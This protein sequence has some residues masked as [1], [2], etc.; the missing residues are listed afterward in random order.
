MFKRLYIPSLFFGLFL[1]SACSEWDDHYENS[2]PSG[3]AGAPLWDQLKS[4]ANLSDFCEVLENT[5]LYRMHKKTP[6]TYADLLKNGQAFTVLAP[7]NN[8]FNKDSLLNLVQTVSGDSAVEKSFVQNHLS[9]LLV[10]VNADSVRMMMLN[11]KRLNVVNGKVEGVQVAQANKHSRNGVLHVL[12]KAVDY[13]RNIY[14]MLCDHPQLSEIGMNLSRFNEDI[15]DPDASVSNGVIE[16]VPVYIDSV[17]YER[18]RMLEQIGLLKEEDSVYWAVVPTTQGWKDAWEVV[19]TYYVF[20]KTN[21]KR[22]SL[23]HYFTM[24][25]LLDDAIFNKT[26]QWDVNDSLLSV[27]YIRNTHSYAKGKHVYNVFKEP[28]KEGGILYGSEPIECSNGIVYKTAKW[29]FTPE[30]T[31]FHEVFV[32]GEAEY[33]MTDYTKCIYHFETHVA[34]SVSENKYIVISPLSSTD[35]WSVTYQLN[36]ILSGCYDIYAITLPKSVYSQKDPDV[37]PNKFNASINYVDEDGKVQTFACQTADGKKEFQNTTERVDTVL[38]AKN[39]KFPTTN[40]NQNT[41]KFSIKITCSITA[42][43]TSSYSREM[44]LDCIYLKPRTSKSEE[45]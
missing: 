44:Y 21:D 41:S 10:S 34:D 27:P 40:Y 19:S 22:D 17:V 1:F 25:A 35:N 16:G 37:R 9:R 38:L 26:D 3:E 24:R 15:F 23:Q 14:E 6:V 42:R 5:N 43:Q 39:F 12:D 33:L 13:N 8:T 7:V 28:F 32:E 31:F 30:Q 18:N 36:D 45:E 4:N 11:S 2:L 20:D 29:P